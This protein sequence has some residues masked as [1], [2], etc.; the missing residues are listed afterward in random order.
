MK[1]TEKAP[2]SVGALSGAAGGTSK[3]ETD[4]NINSTSGGAGRQGRVFPL[5]LAGEANALS[6]AEL[7]QLG[8]SKMSAV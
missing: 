1:R 7:T 8:G 4:S 3:G 6:A 5:L 2:G